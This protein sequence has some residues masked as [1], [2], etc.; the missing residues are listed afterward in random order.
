MS[1]YERKIVMDILLG[2]FLSFPVVIYTGLLVLCVLYWLFAAIGLLAI[3]FLNFDIDVDIDID[4]SHGDMPSTGLGGLLMK[5]GFN[6]VPF[7]LIITLISLIGWIISYFAFQ[8]L[9]LPF[10]DKPWIYYPVGSVVFII[11]FVLAVY[12]TAYIIRPV[13]RLF[14]QLN[15]TNDNKALIGQTV[16][17]RSSIVNKDK[18]EAIYED[19]GAGLILQ[20]RCD[21]SY[22]FKRNDKAV[23]LNY[24]AINNSYQIINYDEFNGS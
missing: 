5:F 9:L 20:V 7:T 10:Y 21:E 12:I 3:D 13:R 4:A 8:L 24:D 22:Q 18:G 1:C 14:E 11:V 2:T 23:L 15:T 16:I 19:G 6:Q 17:I